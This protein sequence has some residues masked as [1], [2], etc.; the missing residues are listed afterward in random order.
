MGGPAANSEAAEDARRFGFPEEVIAAI[1]GADAAGEGTEVWPENWDIVTA[2]VS[3]STQWRAVAMP[4]GRITF[5]GLDYAG[6]RAGL[7]ADGIEV[8]PEL[9]RGIRIMEDASR[10][11]MNGAGR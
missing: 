1:A 3:V 2:F 4:T 7:E 8:T 10:A 11:A 9:W 5:V 6:A